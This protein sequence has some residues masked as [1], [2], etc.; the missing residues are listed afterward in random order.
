M[1][2]SEAPTQPEPGSNRSVAISSAQTLATN[3]LSLALAFAAGV[4]VARAAGPAG[5]GGMDL[6]VATSALLAVVLGLGLPGGL[7]FVVARREADPR[8]LF[9]RVAPI[10]LAMGLA[11]AGVLALIAATPASAAFLVRDQELI[12]GALAAVLVALTLVTSYARSILVGLGEFVTV[13][14]REIATRVLT[15]GLLL[16]VWWLSASS[17]QPPTVAT[18]V[19]VTAL[20]GGVTLALF[21]AALPRPTPGVSGAP[22]RAVMGFAIPTYGA[23]L[24]QF[25]NYRLDIFVV[26]LFLGVRAVGL[27]GLAVSLAQ[28]LWMLSNAASVVLFSRVAS[29]VEPDQLAGLTARVCR[30]V[31]AVT[32][33]GAVALAVLGDPLI[34]RLYGEAFAES[35]EPLLWLL[36]GVVLYSIT[37]VLGAYITGIGRPRSIL[38]VS[39]LGLAVTIPLDLA[40]IPTMGVQGASIA[41][42][43]SYAVAAAAI[44]AIFVRQSHI[45]WLDTVLVRPSDAV[46]AMQLVR[47]MAT[48]AG[49]RTGRAA[50]QGGR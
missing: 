2:A 22:F 33:V 13:N 20:V 41:S 11:A 4:V 10:G 19:L 28:L 23:T 1:S 31:V 16:A 15:L 42:S 25:L 5:K 32:A 17:S 40:L 29:Q 50:G 24:A 49:T 12:T 46:A 39:L 43:A 38:Q 36:P 18:L 45:G 47:A 44:L 7:S 21:A 48:R 37:N 8:A 14:V 27:Y 34:R 26:S 6:T 3:V 30:V 35:V 9:A